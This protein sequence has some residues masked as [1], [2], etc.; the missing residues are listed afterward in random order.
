MGVK[1]G[2]SIDK[3]ILREYFDLRGKKWREAGGYCIMGGF[4]SLYAS[5]DNIRVITQ[6]G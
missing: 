2:L 4:I 6:K 5:P 1:L 3:E